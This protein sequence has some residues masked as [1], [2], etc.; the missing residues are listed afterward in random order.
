M[1]PVCYTGKDEVLKVFCNQ[2]ELFAFFRSGGFMSANS[3]IHISIK[4]LTR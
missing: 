2:G 3:T 1:L 4:M